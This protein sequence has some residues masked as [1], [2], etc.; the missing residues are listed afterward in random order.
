MARFCCCGDEAPGSTIQRE[1]ETDR[2]ESEDEE[3][4]ECDEPWNIVTDNVVVIT[5]DVQNVH[6]LLEYR[7]HIDVSLTCEHDPKLQ[8]Y[9]VCPQNMPQ[10]DSEGIPNQAPET[11][12]PMILNDPTS[13]N[14]EG[15]DQHTHNVTKASY[16]VCYVL[17]KRKKTFSDGEVVKE[18]MINDDESLFNCHNDKSS[19]MSSIRGLQL[20]HQTVAKRVEKIANNL[21]SQLRQNLQSCEYFSLQFDESI[22][23]SDITEFTSPGRSI[24]TACGEIEK[25]V[26]HSTSVILRV[27]ERGKNPDGY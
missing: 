6:L 23:M 2:S 24:T 7:P 15:S 14:L 27:C 12:K 20:S 21:E 17:A 26:P 25:Q 18:A 16:K 9:C 19:L 8:E 13:R 5:E 1:R 10:F 22:D 3:E 11:N 4:G